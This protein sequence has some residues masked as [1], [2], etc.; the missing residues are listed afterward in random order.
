MFCSCFRRKKDSKNIP[1][2]YED[3]NDNDKND[4]DKTI[5]TCIICKCETNLTRINTNIFCKDCLTK[6]KE[7]C[8]ANIIIDKFIE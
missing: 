7:F 3:K 8:R 1:L 2:L 4:N 5:H 6:Y